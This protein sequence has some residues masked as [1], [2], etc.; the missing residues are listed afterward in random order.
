[1]TISQKMQVIHAASAI[2]GLFLPGYTNAAFPTEQ[3]AVHITNF[4][5]RIPETPAEGWQEISHAIRINA[6]PASESMYYAQYVSFST[7]TDDDE[8]YYYGIQPQG[9]GRALV[10]FSYFGKGGQPVDTQHCSQGADGGEGVSCDTVVIPF[11]YGENYIFSAKLIG[12]TK[13][14]NIWEGSVVAASTNVRTKL[15]SWGTPKSI[16]Y[17]SGQSIGFIEAYM[18]IRSCADIP[19]TSAYFSPGKAARTDH[20]IVTGNIIETYPVG[21]CDGKVAFHASAEAIGGITLT[22]S[23]GRD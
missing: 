19:A 1:M 13:N 23:K 10:L 14:E 2:L 21:V 11:K 12:E 17:L 5:G 9:N 4:S 20:S 8:G 7:A 6:G 3:Y 18:G 16:G 22:Q 15:G